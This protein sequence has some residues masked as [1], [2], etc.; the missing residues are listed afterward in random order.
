M[1]KLIVVGSLMP[2]TACFG[3]D[4]Q[5][6]LRDGLRKPMGDLAS[7]VATHGAPGPVV[8]AVRVVVATYESGAI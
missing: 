2:L 7:A 5:S 6:A 3:N 1:R 8:S 4:S